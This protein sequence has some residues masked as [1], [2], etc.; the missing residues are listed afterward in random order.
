MPAST[1]ISTTLTTDI[2]IVTKDTS[3]QEPARKYTRTG[4]HRGANRVDTIVIPT[5]RGT[6]PFAT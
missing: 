5:D 1:G 6:S 2:I 4:V 3:T